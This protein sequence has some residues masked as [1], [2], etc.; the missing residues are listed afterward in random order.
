M[1]LTKIKIRPDTL[2]FRFSKLIYSFCIHF[3]VCHCIHLGLFANISPC[4]QPIER[5]G[6][7]NGHDS[8][9]IVLHFLSQVG[10][11][12]YDDRH[13]ILHC[14]HHRISTDD[15]DVMDLLAGVVRYLHVPLSNVGLFLP[16]TCGSYNGLQ[17]C[18]YHSDNS[19]LP[20]WQSLL[21]RLLQCVLALWRY[22][23]GILP[24]P[25]GHCNLRKRHTVYI[26]SI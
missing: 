2:A 9:S 25:I 19:R 6:V 14:G 7:N 4:T 8:L 10:N 26:Y 5:I 1:Q 24:I 16:P 15:T 22:Y 3:R 23:R 21:F 13:I 20:I 12:Y 11:V 17:H 18:I